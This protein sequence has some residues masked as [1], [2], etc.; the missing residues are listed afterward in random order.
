MNA[1]RR[2]KKVRCLN[3]AS[4]RSEQLP[5]GTLKREHTQL[6]IKMCVMEGL[7]RPTRP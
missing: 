6:Q 4:K 1:E 7:A 5:E 3:A 2:C